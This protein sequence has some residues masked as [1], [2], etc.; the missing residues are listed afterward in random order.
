MRLPHD[1]MV[2]VADGEHLHIFRVEGN[3]DLPHL[4]AAGHPTVEGSNHS[5]GARH[6][7]SAANPDEKQD[8]KDMYAAATAAMLNEQAL[9]NA[10]EHA[11]VI[12][13]PKMLGELRKHFHKAFEAKILKEIPKDLT[14]QTS[15]QIAKAIEHA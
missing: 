6:H 11:V 10:F 4:R 14:G 9:A 5:G 13:P 8:A 7:S 3:E 2:A 15:E 1:T 12:A